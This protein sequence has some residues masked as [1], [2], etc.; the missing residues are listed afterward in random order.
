[1]GVFVHK[2]C[3]K[4]DLRYSLFFGSLIGAVRHQGFIPWDDD[5]DLA[6]PRP[7]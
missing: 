5:L 6:L 2:V 7:D 3:E 4:H 1:M